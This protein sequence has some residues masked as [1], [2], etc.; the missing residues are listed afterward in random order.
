MKNKIIEFNHYYQREESGCHTKNVDKL[1]DWLR[2]YEI[3]IQR[4][5]E[6]H[7]AE[8][9]LIY[10]KRFLA[11]HASNAAEIAILNNNHVAKME[12]QKFMIDYEQD[13]IVSNS[14]Y[15]DRIERYYTILSH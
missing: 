7:I 9:I 3:V 11:Y 2:A 6:E 5:Q 13:Y 14:Q 10:V 1:R 4:F 8:E 15:P 12:F